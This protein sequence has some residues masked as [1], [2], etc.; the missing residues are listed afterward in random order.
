M[1]PM[2]LFGSSER[3]GEIRTLREN[4][5]QYGRTFARMLLQAHVFRLWANRLPLRVGDLSL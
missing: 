2:R 3:R 5:P 4:L 1:R